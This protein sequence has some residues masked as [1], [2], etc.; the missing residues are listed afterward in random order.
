MIQDLFP[1]L[2]EK[3]I[4]VSSIKKELFQKF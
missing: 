4:Q 3:Y 1:H 2:S